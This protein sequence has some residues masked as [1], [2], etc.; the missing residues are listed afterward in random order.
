MR[1]F[2]FLITVRCNDSKP[3]AVFNPGPTEIKERLVRSL[4]DIEHEIEAGSTDSGGLWT[5]DEE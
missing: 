2:E 4:G 1:E 3:Y 5:P